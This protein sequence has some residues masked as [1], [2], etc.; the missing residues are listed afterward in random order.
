MN[1]TT[2]WSYTEDNNE[3]TISEPDTASGDFIENPSKIFDFYNHDFK[4]KLVGETKVDIG[5]VY[6]L[7]LF[8]NNLDQPYSRFKVYVKRDTDEL[9]MIK[10]IGKD[11]IDYTANLKDTKYNEPIPD[12]SFI[13][14]PEK[15]KGIEIVDM[16]F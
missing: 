12:A 13:F 5:W 7:D 3:V 14:Q 1:G 4:Y 15:H 2:L 8:P 10:A 9:S 16:R 11:G 6:E